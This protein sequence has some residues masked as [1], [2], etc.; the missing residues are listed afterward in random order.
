MEVWTPTSCLLCV[1]HDGFM[2]WFG[3]QAKVCR[4]Q[5]SARSWSD[6]YGVD[7]ISCRHREYPAKCLQR[8]IQNEV[9]V[10]RRAWGGR[11]RCRKGCFFRG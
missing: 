7:R 5:L 1:R 3:F 4:E 9:S 2:S 6:F 8:R 11:E 10:T